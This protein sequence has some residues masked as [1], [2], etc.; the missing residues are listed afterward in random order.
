MIMI[1]VLI[2]P[3]DKAYDFEVN[4]NIIKD[5]LLRFIKALVAKREKVQFNSE[6]SELF[7]FRKGDFINSSDSLH[8]QGIISG[9]R[10]I[11]V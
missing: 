9:D 8:K 2:P 6:N 11:L 4:E 1:D 5:E 7:F 3:L 10:L